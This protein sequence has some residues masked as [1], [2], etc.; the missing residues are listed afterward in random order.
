[1]PNPF[2]FFKCN[3]INGCR[4][5]DIERF[6]T[7]DEVF[8]LNAHIACTSRSVNAAINANWIVEISEKEALK[9]ISV[10]AIAEPVEKKYEI[11]EKTIH[12]ADMQVNKA[13]FDR[14]QARLKKLE[15]IKEEKEE[16]VE[17]AIRIEPGKNA[18][19]NL[20]ALQ[21]IQNRNK[22]VKSAK[23]Q[24][25]DFIDEVVDVDREGRKTAFEI[26]KQVSENK[27]TPKTEQVVKKSKNDLKQELE[28]K[29]QKKI[30]EKKT[31][32]IIK[33]ELVFEEIEKPKRGRPTKPKNDVIID[34][35]E[36]TQKVVVEEVIPEKLKK[37][38]RPKKEI[39]VEKQE[40]SKKRA[41]RPAGSK[42]KKLVTA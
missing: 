4:L 13:A 9:S 39:K 5:S 28:E 42:N 6:V 31:V 11:E 20:G 33:E 3:I 16:K 29:F 17:E 12:S 19:E 26:S 24:E 18:N 15:K 38:G 32:K 30:S 7:R 36:I 27:T 21:R 1:M 2:R 41:G 8:Y 14:H 37:A 40:I 22:K 35:P 34:T 10:P 23:R 25:N